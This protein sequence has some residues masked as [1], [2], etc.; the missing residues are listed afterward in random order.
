MT[1]GAAHIMLELERGTEVIAGHLA[2][3]DQ[4]V[5]FRGWLVLAAA[6]ERIRRSGKQGNQ[7]PKGEGNE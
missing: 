3:G 6:L 2:V 7:Q 1:D 4:A 5:P